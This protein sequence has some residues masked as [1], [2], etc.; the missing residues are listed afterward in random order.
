MIH[1]SVDGGVEGYALQVQQHQKF[2]AESAWLV[3]C[4]LQ[5]MKMDVG[6]GGFKLQVLQVT[7]GCQSHAAAAVVGCQH[8]HAG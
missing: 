8:M 3:V 5:V 4:F 1:Y 2:H 7:Q 6:G